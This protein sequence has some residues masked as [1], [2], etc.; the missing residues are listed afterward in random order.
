MNTVYCIVF[1]PQNTNLTRVSSPA[2]IVF[3]LCVFQLQFETALL[4]LADVGAAAVAV[5]F[6]L[7]DVD[8]VGCRLVLKPDPLHFVDNLGE[9]G[10]GARG[11]GRGVGLGPPRSGLLQGIQ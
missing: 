2:K 5:P 1:E 6:V 7:V 10:L 4:L 9:V 8:V 3:V 11:S